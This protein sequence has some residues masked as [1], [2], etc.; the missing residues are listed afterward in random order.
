MSPPDGEKRS[1]RR[2]GTSPGLVETSPGL[3]EFS[4]ELVV[5]RGDAVFTRVVTVYV[6][7]VTFFNAPKASWLRRPNTEAGAVDFLR[8]SRPSRIVLGDGSLHD[9]GDERGTHGRP[10]NTENAD[11]VQEHRAGGIH[12]IFKH[13]AYSAA[14]ASVA[15]SVAAS[16]AG[17][18]VSAAAFL[19]R[20]VRVVFFFGVLAM[21]SS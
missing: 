19:E 2:V 9:K 1:V 15:A 21:L 14:G 11:P 6:K 10:E 20:R 8:F 4:P 5:T 18:S 16:T 12:E 13:R 7:N 17:A 3:V